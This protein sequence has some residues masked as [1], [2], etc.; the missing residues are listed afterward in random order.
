MNKSKRWLTTAFCLILLGAILFIVAMTANHWDFEKLST[1]ALVTNEYSISEDVISIRVLTDTAD[2]LLLPTDG[3]SC[4][5]VCEEYEPSS[6]TVTAHHGTLTVE[7]AD[8]RKWYDHIGIGIDKAKIT[9]Y[10]PAATYSLLSVDTDTGDITVPPDFTFESITLSTDTGDVTLAAS[11][12]A[13]KLKTS[14][15]DVLAEHIRASSFSCR[16]TTGNVT[17]T[18]ATVEA[19]VG[20]N[21][22]TGRVRLTDVTCR[23]LYSVGDTGDIKLTRVVA[24]ETFTIRRSTG[25]VR[26]DRCDASDV[27]ITTD[28]GDVEG[29]LL[30]PKIFNALTDTGRMQVPDSSGVGTCKIITDTGDIKI[31]IEQ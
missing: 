18:D 4:R 21:V 10:L 7:I 29:S 3:T 2:V 28:T 13:V 5:V 31:R 30:T 22:S 26:L 16:T 11:A 23:D 27:S 8:Q 6:H 24:E 1:K 25:D 12:S 9:I 19:D 17:L 20:V 14:T 15:G